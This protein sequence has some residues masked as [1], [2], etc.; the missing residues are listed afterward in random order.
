MI[1][2][3]IM[4]PIH[5]RNFLKQTGAVAALAAFGSSHASAKTG[6]ILT[7]AEEIEKRVRAAR[8]LV[9]GTIPADLKTGW[10]PPITTATTTSRTNRFCLKV[11]RPSS[12]SE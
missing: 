7:S 8:P 10:V 1:R 11:R 12:G 9:G 6:P 4:T 2:S 5:R 3:F